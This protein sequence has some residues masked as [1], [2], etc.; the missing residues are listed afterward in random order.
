VRHL[1][2]FGFGGKSL[3]SRRSQELGN[4]WNDALIEDVLVA[5]VALDIEVVRAPP[6]PFRLRRQVPFIWIAVTDETR[7]DLRLARMRAIIRPQELRSIGNNP[8]PPSLP[9]AKSPCARGHPEDRC[10]PIHDRTH[11]VPLHATEMAGTRD[12]ND[13]LIKAISFKAKPSLLATAQVRGDFSRADDFPRV[14]IGPLDEVRPR[15]C[16]VSHT[17]PS[18]EP[19]E[20]QLQSFLKA[21]FS[22]DQP[23]SPQSTVRLLQPLPGW[24]SPS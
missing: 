8:P 24:P 17:P 2:H 21:Y 19:V 14:I 23:Q 3:L 16:T 7:L 20:V 6:H 13:P 18:H 12:E 11:E 15:P 5:V 1:I 9:A 22:K 10:P 4:Q